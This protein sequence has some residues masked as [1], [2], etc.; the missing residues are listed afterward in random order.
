MTRHWICTWDLS[1]L[2]FTAFMGTGLEMLSQSPGTGRE[3]VMIHKSLDPDAAFHGES[4]GLASWHQLQLGNRWSQEVPWPQPAVPMWGTK[5]SCPT[6]LLQ[7]HLQPLDRHRS[8]HHFAILQ[9]FGRQRKLKA[10]YCDCTNGL[11]HCI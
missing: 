10:E 9:E 7:K 2:F 1:P 3:T 11:R 5:P 4:S 8:T 6:M